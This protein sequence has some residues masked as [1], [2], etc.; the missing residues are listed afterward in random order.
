MSCC[1][2]ALNAEATSIKLER[3][4]NPSCNDLVYHGKVG[5][6]KNGVLEK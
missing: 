1:G 4:N 2:R 5:K 3:E 6:I